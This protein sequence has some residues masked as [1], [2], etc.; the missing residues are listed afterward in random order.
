KTN[1]ERIGGVLDVTTEPGVGTTFRIK[2]PLTLA[3][4]PALMVGCRG[5]H[6]AIPQVTLDELVRIAREAVAT[7]IEGI[8]GAAVHRLRGQLLPLVD[9]A[10]VLGSG[11]TVIDGSEAVNVVVLQADGRR[12]GLVVDEITDT[13]EIVVKPLGSHLKDLHMF[14]GATI[15]GDGRVALILDT[16]GLAQE[17]NVGSGVARDADLV[18]EADDRSRRAREAVLV[19]DLGDGHRGALMLSTVARLEQLSSAAIEASSRGPVVQYRGELLPLVSLSAL[20]GMGTGRPLVASEEV[21]DLDVV[22]WTGPE[23]QIGLVVDRI[24]D[25]V[26]DDLQV[27]VGSD[28]SVVAVV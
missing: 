2:I 25:I 14:A 18:D 11:T 6:F 19:V 27:S 4:I 7:E 20:T 17:A 9:L 12:F 3:I 22:V 1:I 26:D 15:L 24:L 21:D 8:D 13:Q 5:G 16:V 28:G 23:G 10:Q